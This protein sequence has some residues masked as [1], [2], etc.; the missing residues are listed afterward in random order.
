MLDIVRDGENGLV[1]GPDRPADLA[2]ALH[3]LVKDPTLAANLA[4]RGRR[5]V[6][7]RFDAATTAAAMAALL[8]GP[9][10]RR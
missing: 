9:E 5:T 2:D 1:V 10:S 8:T 7:E 6:A 3:R 4:E